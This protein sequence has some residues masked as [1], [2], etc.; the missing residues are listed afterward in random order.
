MAFIYRQSPDG[1]G[2]MSAGGEI[3][4]WASTDPDKKAE[5]ENNIDAKREENE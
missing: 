2:E 5:E 4:V 1:G 3:T